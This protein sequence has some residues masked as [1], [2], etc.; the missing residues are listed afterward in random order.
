VG[1]QLT[2]YQRQQDSVC[3]QGR[4]IRAACDQGAPVRLRCLTPP[5]DAAHPE[6]GVA[7]T[8]DFTVD[9][10]DWRSVFRGGTWR[11]SALRPAACEIFAMRTAD[12]SRLGSA[13]GTNEEAYLFQKLV[14]VGFGSNNGSL[15]ASLSCIQC[16]RAE[17][18]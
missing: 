18:N 8:K 4:R 5:H 3:G 17:K 12:R 15:H 9:P 2:Y 16:R 7:K 11:S 6:V 13:K 14:R 1:C 10:E